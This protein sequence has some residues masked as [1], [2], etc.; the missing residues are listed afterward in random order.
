M[1]S[2]SPQADLR[3]IAAALRRQLQRTPASVRDGVERT[4]RNLPDE[5]LA[6]LMR[7]PA[8][9]VLLD[10]IFRQ[11][12]RYLEPSRAQGVS[13]LVRWCVTGGPDGATDVYHVEIADGRC[14]VKRGSDDRRA[15]LTV[16]LDGTE[17]I[18]LATGAADPMRAYFS[19]RVVLTGDVMH[20][21]KLATMFR[22][23]S[24]GN[25]SNGGSSGLGAAGRDDRPTADRV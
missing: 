5:R 25:G 1:S 22:R 8:R 21:A 23:P 20:A 3:G 4:I 14:L 15:Q 6:W 13:S 9:R 2:E 19:G 11:M 7:S 17:L 16:T 10:G 12:P 24:A 18:K